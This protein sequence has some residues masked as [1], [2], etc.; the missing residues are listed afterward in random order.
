VL[1]ALWQKI[2]HLRKVLEGEAMPD[3][4]ERLD[5]ILED[6][7]T[8]HVSDDAYQNV[9]NATIELEQ[10]KKRVAELEK[11]LQHATDRL[12]G[13]LALGVR[14]SQPSLHC[15]LG[16]GAC[17]V[18]YLKKSL[19]LRPDLGRSMWLVDASHPKFGSRFRRRNGH[20]LHMTDNLMPLAQGVAD[21]FTNFYRTLGEDEGPVKME[22]QGSIT[23]FES[24]SSRRLSLGQLGQLVR[25]ADERLRTIKTEVW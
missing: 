3:I 14:R 20:L 15:Q 13:G 4:T 1:Q 22:G 18:G 6:D 12:C 8:T 9:R 2:R 19:T 7:G 11:E 25:V 24:G 21:F 5:A 23:L 16:N 17:K 10:A